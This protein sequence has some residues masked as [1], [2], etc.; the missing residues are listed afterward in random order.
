MRP[1]EF[2]MTLPV[3]GSSIGYDVDLC[4]TMM[5]TCR[6]PFD[7]GLRREVSYHVKKDCMDHLA[8]ARWKERSTHRR[9]RDR[10][11]SGEE[12]ADINLNR[13]GEIE[14]RK[15]SQRDICPCLFP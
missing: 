6:L 3:S 7:R 10:W 12:F 15:F 13:L 4:L 8:V 14:R 2:R 5:C 1:P 11:I 9:S